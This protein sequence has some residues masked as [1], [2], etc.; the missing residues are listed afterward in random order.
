[1][2]RPRGGKGRSRVDSGGSRL[3]LVQGS[4]AS[5]GKRSSCR[6]VICWRRESTAI[7]VI[8]GELDKPRPRTDTSLYQVFCTCSALFRL[9]TCRLWNRNHPRNFGTQ[10]TQWWLED[11]RDGATRASLFFCRLWLRGDGLLIRPEQ[12][13]PADLASI[14]QVLPW[15]KVHVNT[16]EIRERYLAPGR[17]YTSHLSTAATV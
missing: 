9:L 10:N 8:G 5:K 16:R 4:G 6:M 11:T 7:R 17:L 1:V 14:Q 2:G 3:G 15:A 13:W 12:R